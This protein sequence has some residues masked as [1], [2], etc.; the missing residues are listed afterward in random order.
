MNGLIASARDELLFADGNLKHP[1]DWSR[2]P[3]G[4]YIV[5]DGS[6]AELKL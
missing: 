6:G 2:G 3:D 1:S 5:F 4:D